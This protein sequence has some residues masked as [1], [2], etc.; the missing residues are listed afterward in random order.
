MS[1][2]ATPPDW[3]IAEV[4][5][6]STKVPGVKKRR[7]KEGMEATRMASSI[8]QSG[9][10]MK[11]QTPR[12]NRVIKCVVVERN[13]WRGEGREAKRLLEAVL[14]VWLKERRARRRDTLIRASELLEMSPS[15][16]S[17]SL[18]CCSAPFAAGFLR[19][20]PE[21]ATGNEPVEDTD[22]V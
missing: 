11:A 20:R 5:L 18:S 2:T 6:F 19:N 14:N 21:S 15:P 16:L 4:M 8:A 1:G 12:R 3:R 17:A 9:G 22:E 7:C 10:F 13:F